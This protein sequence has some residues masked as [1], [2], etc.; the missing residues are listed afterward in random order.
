NVETGARYL[1]RVLPYRSIGNVIEGL[2]LTFLDV[3]PIVRAEE[4]LG[5]SE[6]RLRSVVEG[7]PQL[8]W[9]ASDGGEWSWSSPQWTSF[10]G[11]GESAA[12]GRGWLEPIHRD[13]RER[14][15]RAWAIAEES[16]NFEVDHRLWNKGEGAYRNVH[17]RATPVKDSSG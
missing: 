13:D 9:R 7:I 3:T 14:V 17:M 12:I 1:T 5:E 2:V 8:V 15:L 6:S 10:T 11:Q 4:R 16:G